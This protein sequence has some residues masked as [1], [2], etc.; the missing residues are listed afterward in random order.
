[1]GDW[2]LSIKSKTGS[3]RINNLH[4]SMSLKDL[5]LSIS[6]VV[7]I[8]SD[9]L[10]ILHGFPP[11]LLPDNNENATLAELGLSHGSNLVVEEDQA[12]KKR[13][14]MLLAENAARELAAQ[15]NLGNEGYLARVTVPA[16][17]SCLF[18]SIDYVLHGGKLNLS[19]AESMREV[20]AGVVMSQPNI[21][22]DAFLGK[23]NAD[24]C[25]WILKDDSWGGAIE[26]DILSN[27]NKIEIDVVDCQTGR[28][29]RF[30]EDKFYQN[31]ILLIY[32][33]IHY[34]P[35]VFQFADTSRAPKTQFS[36]KDEQILGLALELGAEAKAS[37]AFT[38]VSNFSLRCITCN[39]GLK[40]QSEAQLHAQKTGHIN[41]G[42][43]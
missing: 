1:M 25:D 24:Y 18:T 11:K 36:T 9:S 41:F 38:D 32:D 29:D 37:R 27:L 12:K 4:G 39:Q 28:I 2:I 40:G 23:S 10:K 35:I 14:E 43:I 33:G 30:G 26:I 5:K 21:Y 3:H 6:Q 31:R 15:I 22:N 20:I 17:N 19:S 16:N 7:K 13:Q 42:E 34:D 8:S